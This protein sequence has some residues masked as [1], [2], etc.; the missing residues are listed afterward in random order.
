[1]IKDKSAFS[2]MTWINREMISPAD[3]EQT[4]ILPMI[5]QPGRQQIFVRFSD[6]LYCCRHVVDMA[7]QLPPPLAKTLSK[8]KI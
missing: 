7:S 8:N 6:R 1:M 3:V 5:L 4:Y 2:E